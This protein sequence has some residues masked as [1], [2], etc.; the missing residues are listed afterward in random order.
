ML[1]TG[2]AVTLPLVATDTA[3]ARQVTLV[4]VERPAN[5]LVRAVNLLCQIA[6]ILVVIAAAWLVWSRPSAM[7]WG[8]FLYANWFNP[9]Q[10]D[11]F[12]AILD[13][14]PLALLVQDIAS[15]FAEGAAYA[16]FLLFVLRV[17]NNTTEPRWRP[18]E[19]ALPFV[20]LFFS[21][22]LL[23]SYASAFGYPSEAITRAT[24][25]FGFAVDLCALGI[26]LA[27]LATPAALS[28][29]LSPRR[30]RFCYLFP[31]FMAS[32]NLAFKSGLMPK[33][34]TTSL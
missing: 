8:F 21:V 19:R 6:G 20:A 23:A 29:F 9:G 22:V 34:S 15:C 12:Y 2:K 17:P 7:N 5:F 1:L 27:A 31:R 4:A 30:Y 18:V 26:L 13:Q 24:I 3:P 25:L 16:G 32:C 33:N 14:W 28:A 10:E 11:A